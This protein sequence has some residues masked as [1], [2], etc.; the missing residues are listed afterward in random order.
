MQLIRERY[1]WPGMW[2]YIS[3]KTKECVA[4]SYKKGIRYFL[5]YNSTNA[6][7][8]WNSA[9][10]PPLKPI[11][12]QPKAWWRVHADILGPLK[13]SRNGNQYVAIAVDSLTKY[14]EA[15]RIGFYHYKYTNFES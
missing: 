1:Y 7:L 14:V 15:M 9:S 12:V 11:L 2:K 3:E 5:A 10:L 8:R 13:M 6:P 4:C